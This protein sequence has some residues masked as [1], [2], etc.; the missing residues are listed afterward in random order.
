MEDDYRIEYLKAHILAM[1]DA[2][3]IDGV[4]I[5]VNSVPKWSPFSLFYTGLKHADSSS[6]YIL[7][8]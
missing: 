7:L 3:E 5:M 8:L 1:M 2:V 6:T 4:E